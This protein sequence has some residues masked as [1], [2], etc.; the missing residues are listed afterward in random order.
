MKT[1]LLVRLDKIGDLVL[2]LPVDQQPSLA[3]HRCVWLV[4]QGMGFIPKHAS[5][6]RTYFELS[7]KIN[8]KN[9]SQLWKILKSLQPDVTVSFQAPWW[10]NFAFF[11]FGVQ[12]RIGVLSRWHSF[13]LFNSGLRQK[14]SRAESNEL[15]YNHQLV[16]H[17]FKDPQK[18]TYPHL[19]LEAPQAPPSM[20]LPQSYIVVHPGMAGSARNWPSDKYIELLE[21]L[22]LQK[23]HVIVTG[24]KADIGYIKP[25]QEKIIASP[26]IFWWNEKL[27]V[28]Q[29]LYVLAKADH[30]IAPSTGVLHLAAA[31]G[32]SVT[33]IYSPVRVQRVKRWGPQGRSVQTLVPAVDCPGTLGCIKE[34]CS[35]FDCMALVTAPE[36]LHTISVAHKETKKL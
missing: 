23:T 27:S 17:G 25:L 28:D 24:T 6:A 12:K 30:V 13:L 29:L 33:G 26:Y 16:H 2:T 31:L 1:A 36:I 5:P 11:I 10:I 34:K 35:F 20:P 9:W 7:P 21:S 18:I 32:T 4:S 14:R 22:A 19:Q 8:F 3:D 15:E